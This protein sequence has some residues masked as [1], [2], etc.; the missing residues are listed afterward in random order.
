RS[1]LLIAA[2]AMVSMTDDYP[3][4]ILNTEAIDRCFLQSDSGLCLASK[5][6]Y[7]YNIE[8][9]VCVKFTYGGCGGNSNR[10]KQLEDCQTACG[11]AALAHPPI[12][13]S[14]DRCYLQ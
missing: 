7:Y 8:R 1:L 9:G 10:F 14:N 3:S 2:I 11:E 13:A 4:S 6:S 5:P 12:L